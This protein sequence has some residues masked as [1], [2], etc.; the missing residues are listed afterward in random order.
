[1]MDTTLVTEL[2]A[3]GC[4]GLVTISLVLSW[5]TKQRG[6]SSADKL[7]EHHRR[8]QQEVVQVREAIRDLDVR[9]AKAELVQESLT[10]AIEGLSTA[11]E[12]QTTFLGTLMGEIKDL[13]RDVTKG[14]SV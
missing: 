9:Y 11:I 1:M 4:F 13:Q 7:C 14:V 10:K 2:G 6:A 3:I 8:T 12:K 5:V